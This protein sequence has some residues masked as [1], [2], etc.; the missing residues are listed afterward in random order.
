MFGVF[1]N[2][3]EILTYS[4]ML[5]GTNSSSEVYVVYVRGDLKKSSRMLL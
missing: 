5:V 1:T 4:D 3:R 2:I